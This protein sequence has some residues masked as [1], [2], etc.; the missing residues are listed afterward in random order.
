MLF[1]LAERLGRTVGELLYGSPGHRPIS[2][3]EITEWAALWEL[4]AWEQD[5]AAKKA[6]R[7]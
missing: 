7:K 2:A 4:R 5:Q 3:M 1:E 6:K